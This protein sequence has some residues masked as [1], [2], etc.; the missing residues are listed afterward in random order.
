M[1]TEETKE[2]N[3]NVYI[4]ANN[5]ES[6]KLNINKSG[7]KWSFKSSS[8]TE[9]IEKKDIKKLETRYTTNCK[10]NIKTSI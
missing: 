6:I 5:P 7:L 3:Y 4:G 9:E 2:L 10:L 1:T 8:E